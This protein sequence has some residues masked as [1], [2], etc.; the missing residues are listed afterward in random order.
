MEKTAI[1]IDVAIPGDK[2]ITDKEKDKV[3]KYQNLKREI[4]WLWNLKKIDLKKIVRFQTQRIPIKNWP[5]SQC[6]CSIFNYYMFNVSY[7]F[8]SYQEKDDWSNDWSNQEFP[9]QNYL[10]DLISY[11]KGHRCLFSFKVWRCFLFYAQRLSE[12]MW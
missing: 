1:I 4:Q 6:D 12:E 2:G 5:G 9:F 11:N 8:F 10:K 7:Y 3:Q